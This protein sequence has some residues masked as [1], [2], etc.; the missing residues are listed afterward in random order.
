MRQN[1]LANSA[2]HKASIDFHLIEFNASNKP[3]VAYSPFPTMFSAIPTAVTSPTQTAS[4]RR[5]VGAAHF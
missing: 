5:Q 4:S 3:T 2:Y 1:G